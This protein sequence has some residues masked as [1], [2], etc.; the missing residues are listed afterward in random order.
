M[1]AEFFLFEVCSNAEKTTIEDLAQILMCSP[2]SENIV[3]YIKD[4]PFV[5]A[6]DTN[7]LFLL[8]IEYNVLEEIESSA[9]LMYTLESVSDQFYLKDFTKRQVTDSQ[10]PRRIRSVA[11]ALTRL[12]KTDKYLTVEE[13]QLQSINIDTKTLWQHWKAVKQN[14]NTRFV[15]QFSE[16]QYTELHEKIQIQEKFIQD[17]G[18]IIAELPDFIAELKDQQKFIV[19]LKDAISFVLPLFNFLIPKS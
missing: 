10:N 2:V 11:G 13:T 3:E 18:K 9:A 12:F 17:Q 7:R 16:A 15:S 5:L 14:R 19:A 1:H 8:I 6:Y 4:T